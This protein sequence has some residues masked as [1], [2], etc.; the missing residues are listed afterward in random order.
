MAPG[1]RFATDIA[2]R[3]GIRSSTDRSGQATISE[4]ENPDNAMS[5]FPVTVRGLH[6][7]GVRFQDR[8]LM[9]SRFSGRV[10]AGSAR[11]RLPNR[12]IVP[13]PTEA[14]A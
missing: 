9:E 12:P 14:M 6:S 2:S 11:W 1:A 7:A 5:A 8:P 4:R 13:F 10:N 3:Y